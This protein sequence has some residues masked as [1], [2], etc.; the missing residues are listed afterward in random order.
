MLLVI[1]TQNCKKCNMTKSILDKESI[2]YTY[3]LSS[4]IPEEEFNTY[5]NKAKIKGILNFPL[6]IKN[7][8]IITLEDVVK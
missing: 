2:E 8:E 1:G 5:I 6:I 4:E 7:D 3:K